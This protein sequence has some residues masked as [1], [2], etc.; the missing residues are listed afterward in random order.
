MLVE[1]EAIKESLDDDQWGIGWLFY[2][3]V[4][5]EQFLRFAESLRQLVFGRALGRFFNREAS[6]I[7]HHLA[8]H[9]VDRD[10]DAVGH[11]ALGTKAQAEINDGFEGETAFLREIRMLSLQLVQPEF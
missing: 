8:F 4:K 9:I 5:V 7:R 11:H 2:S 6:G 10:G 1:L 3:P